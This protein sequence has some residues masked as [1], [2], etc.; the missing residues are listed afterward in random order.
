MALYAAWTQMGTDL[1][2][3]ATHVRD[4]AAAKPSLNAPAHF[5]LRE[6]CLLEGIL[7]R[8]WQ[9]WNSF[10]RTC[11]VE[12]CMGTLN[13]AGLPVTG[14][15]DALSEAHVS[16]AAIVAKKKPAP[17]YW[18]QTNTVLRSEPT[19]GDT[20]V[21]TSILTRLRPQNS[22]ALLPAISGVHA[23]AK[24]LQTIRNGA[25]HN[26]FQNLA[27]V[28]SL[29][30]VYIAFPITHPTHAMFWIAP[31]S[32]DFLITDVVSDLKDLGLT[33]IS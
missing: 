9:V 32:R 7:S 33:A 11:V 13:A 26:H 28:Q 14:L 22:S 16:A 6:E 17:P 23:K 24:A 25:A 30:S 4:F 21:L 19:W 2:L 20:D 10:C 29:R 18:G 1:D 3:L 15:P 31:Q 8:V 27:E 12:S 5:S